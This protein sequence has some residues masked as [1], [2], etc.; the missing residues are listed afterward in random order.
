MPDVPA[1][2]QDERFTE[3]DLIAD[4]A[5]RSESEEFRHNKALLLATHPHC[6]VN[7]DDCDTGG[8]IEAHHCVE[9]SQAPKVD[10][11]R[12]KATLLCFDPYGY[13]LRLA[14]QPIMSIDDIRNL[15]LLC[16]SHHRGKDRGAH[17][18]TWPTFF[19]MKARRDGES[20]TADEVN[21]T[22]HVPAPEA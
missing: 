21:V 14:A 4:H 3:R 13:S 8:P 18:L 7:S 6:W 1:H 5:E 15:V 22:R 9:W 17:M 12:L 11:V 16:A 19:A 10:F 20:V 2:E